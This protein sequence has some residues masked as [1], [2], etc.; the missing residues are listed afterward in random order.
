M[1][2]EAEALLAPVRSLLDEAA[3]RL[4]AGPSLEVELGEVQ[5]F[6]ERAGA[7]LTLSRALAGPALHHPDEP[8]GPLPPMDRWRRA[9]GAVLEGLALA[10]LEGSVGAPAGQD[11]RWQGAAIALADA[12]APALQLAT[13]D[14]ALAIA[15]ASPGQHPR[16]GAAIFLLLAAWGEAPEEALA[17]LLAA[18]PSPERWLHLGAATLDPEGP[19]AARLPITPPRPARR[20]PPLELAPWSWA[21]LELEH[22]RGGLLQPSGAC[23]A[24]WVIGGDTHRALAAAAAAPLPLSLTPGG[25]VGRWSLGSVSGL[26]PVMGAR[27][28]EL[29]LSESGRLELILADSF[30]G[31]A[32]ALEL[33]ERYGTSGTAAGR[34]RVTGPRAFIMSDIRTRGLTMHSVDGVVVPADATSEGWIQ[35]LQAHAFAWTCQDDLLTL[36]GRMMGQVVELRLRRS[37]PASFIATRRPRDEA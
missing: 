21:R 12:A 15:Q 37:Q 32:A 26:G 5:G 18:P 31:P 20:A 25:P 29:E 17:R 36:R 13:P 10:A 7:R 19:L 2:A 30:V 8:D 1:S 9:T 35:Q 4:P 24:A 33:A 23:D 22:P 28:V 3:E 16:A 27:G 6:A 34:W 14:L 11:W